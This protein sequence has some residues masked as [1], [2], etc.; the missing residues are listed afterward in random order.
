ML[1]SLCSA[2]DRALVEK[3][4]LSAKNVVEKL[5]KP[6]S[7]LKVWIDQR[8]KPSS[9]RICRLTKERNTGSSSEFARTDG[10]SD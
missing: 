1:N 5:L 9:K 4:I 8:E 3:G 6:Q 10:A 7:E 2:C